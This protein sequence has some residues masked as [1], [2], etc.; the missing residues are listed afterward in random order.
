MQGKPISKEIE[1]NR[2]KKYRVVD[3][4]GRGACG[5]TLRLHDDD[6]DVDVV[7]KKYS[8]IISKESAPQQFQELIER[9]RSEARIL[10]QLN[11][12]NIVR[13]FNYYDYSESD[14]SYIIME[15]VSGLDIVEYIDHNPIEFDLVFEKVIGGF[16][17]LEREG[18]LHR[19]IRPSNIL[20]S[21]SGEPKIIDFGFGKQID[22]DLT[23]ENK[24]ISLN[25]WCEA[26]PEFSQSIYDS[27]TEVYFVGKLF[28]HIIQEASLSG[29]KYANTVAK[30]CSAPRA[31]RYQSFKEVLRVLNQELFEDIDF[32]DDEI[33]TYRMFADGLSR[34]F[35]TIGPS[36]NFAREVSTIID[37]LES[38]YQTVR[39]ERD[40]PD[41]VGLCRVFVS[42]EFRYFK[43]NTLEVHLVANFLN[44]LKT[45]SG[46]R[47]EIVIANLISRLDAIPK[48]EPK[49]M[50]LDD[51]I[52][53]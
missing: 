24:S 43:S 37:G 19:D 40:L 4:L 21:G 10:F 14:T 25:W 31:H 12:P 3:V 53:F 29:T 9:F 45:L 39:L 49:P 48:S 6:M 7:V 16:E 23:I 28:E 5:E 32:T 22:V 20:V 50:T 44:L 1:F 42:G 34:I 17:H 2:P 52:P 11:H 51:G 18:I 41:P 33:S 38:L 26:P 15:Y 8:P 36:A 30:M 27:Q 47:K 13:V 35:S 46:S